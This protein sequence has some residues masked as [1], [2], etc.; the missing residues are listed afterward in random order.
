MPSGVGKRYEEVVRWGAISEGAKKR[1]VSHS[2]HECTLELISGDASTMS[3]LL[4]CPCP[5]LGMSD[6]PLRRLHFPAC[7]FIKA[8][9]EHVYA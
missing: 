4:D 9:S 5:T 8:T 1:K 7:L 3:N 6:L 2:D